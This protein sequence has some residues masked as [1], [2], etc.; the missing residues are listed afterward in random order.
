MHKWRN[1]KTRQAKDLVSERTCGFDSHL[2]YQYG[3]MP[4]SGQKGRTVNPL[5]FAYVGSNPT[6]PT[7][8]KITYYGTGAPFRR[9]A[10]SR[11][12]W[13]WPDRD[14]IIGTI[15]IIVIWRDDNVI[16][17]FITEDCTGCGVC[18]DVCPQKCID[19]S[20]R[21]LVILQEHCLHCGSCWRECP[22][23]A[24]IRREESGASAEESESM[25][26]TERLVLRPFRKDDLELI[27]S[28][29]CDEE[30][31]KYMP[32]DTMSVEDAEKHLERIIREW[33]QPPRCNY[34]MAVLLKDTGDRIGRAH[35]EIDRDT[36]TGMIGWLLIQEHWGQ[37]YA[38]EISRALINHCF[39]AFHLHRVNAVCNPE[40]IGSWRVLE[41][42]GMRREA[43]FLK[44]CRYVKHGVIR[45]EDEL[46]YAILS[47][48]YRFDT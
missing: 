41:K 20:G 28:L 5:A 25:I 8:F 47:S 4:E 6:S 38:T 19:I 13:K 48:E 33:G 1:R 23:D 40:N 36:D 21:P 46:E 9:G 12:R 16:E 14:G 37:G 27:R 32:S 42:C 45:W 18:V 30:I 3:R 24:L 43:C 11:F 15:K 2:V 17:Y 7:I 26:K 22:S 44:K 29:Y 10:F 39:D 34:E 35:I 31:L